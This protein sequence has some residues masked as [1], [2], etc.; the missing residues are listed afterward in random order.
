MLRFTEALNKAAESGELRPMVE[1]WLDPEI[2]YLPP[3]GV[4][5]PGPYRGRDEMEAFYEFFRDQF[6]RIRITVRD[7][8]E[9]NGR[10]LY[11]QSVEVTGTGSGA[12]VADDSFCVATVRAGR[13]LR[14]VEDYDRAEALR[15]AGLESSRSK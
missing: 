13:L 4:P 8:A 9:S 6:D 10:V 14:I 12:V 3:P 1:R 7:L 2:E 5:E 11:R 15:R